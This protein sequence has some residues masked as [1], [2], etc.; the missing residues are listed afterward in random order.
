MN[1]YLCGFQGVG[2]S[3]FGKMVSQALKRPFFDLDAL[4]LRQFDSV[5]I[6]SL[7]LKVGQ[8]EF[9][10]AEEKELHTL[11]NE[12]NGAI[13]S[14]GGG[15]LESRNNQMAVAKG[16]LIY[17]FTPK[18]EVQKKIEAAK[19]PPPYLDA[20]DSFDQFFDSR[21]LTFLEAANKV[22][23]VKSSDITIKEIIDYALK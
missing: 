13:I 10:H 1:L 7:W 8:A 6:R 23:K 16:C 2:K 12:Q 14:L 19:D 4:L 18:N 20:Y 17:L 5:D 9:R 3:Y 22:I 15:A 21:H 11:S